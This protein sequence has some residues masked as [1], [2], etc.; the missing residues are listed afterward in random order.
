MNEEYSISKLADSLVYH[1]QK[2]SNPR[3][4]TFVP[5][6]E[7]NCSLSECLALQKCCLG[8]FDVLFGCWQMYEANITENH[9]TQ[10]RAVNAC[11]H[12]L[13]LAR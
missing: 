8:T 3:S 12:A 7:L 9:L 10:Q 5:S 4:P 13:T 6:N 11:A 1:T 2:S